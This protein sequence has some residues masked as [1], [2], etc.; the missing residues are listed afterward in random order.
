MQSGVMAKTRLHMPRRRLILLLVLGCLVLNL[1]VD[2]ALGLALLQSRIHYEVSAQTNVANLSKV[3]EQNVL[4]L[5]KEIDLTLK[6]V[7]D[8][9]TRVGAI[10][11]PANHL[12]LQFLENQSARIPEIVGLRVID[13]TGDVIYSTNPMPHPVNEG[14]REHFIRVRDDPNADRSDY[15][16]HHW[17]C[18]Q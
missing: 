5:I 7:A 4:T 11:K 1:A 13:Q 6:T 8:E 15:R 9:G 12:F 2:G 17:S 18:H 3:L 16:A 14:D 10:T